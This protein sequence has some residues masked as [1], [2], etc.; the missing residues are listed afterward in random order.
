MDISAQELISRY[1]AQYA[2]ELPKESRD[3]ERRELE[4]NIE[5]MVQTRIE[6]GMNERHAVED[7]L[8][9]LGDPKDLAAETAGKTGGF[10]SLSG[11]YYKSFITTLP[12]VI[13]WTFVIYLM[14]SLLFFTLSIISGMEKLVFFN[15]YSLVEAV[16]YAGFITFIIY[17]VLEKAKIPLRGKAWS[18]ED[19]KKDQLAAN[20]I[21]RRCTTLLLLFA[22]AMQVLL[23]FLPDLLLRFTTGSNQEFIRESL[24]RGEVNWPSLLPYLTVF[25]G[26]IIIEQVYRLIHP[27][28]D[29]ST[30]IV[31][32]VINIA[33]VAALILFSLRVIEMEVIKTYVDSYSRSTS[34]TSVILLLVL[35]FALDSWSVFRKVR[36]AE[37]ARVEI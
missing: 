6:Q 14:L 16:I 23:I 10:L 31:N 26:I 25:F 8:S 11:Q 15:D 5:D 22:V 18:V 30:L 12:L 17:L 36:A 32:I 19:L 21:S 35:I 9:E 28:W 24:L 33:S 34:L 29:K 13:F 3:D 2:Q 20:Y 37:V 7:V 27:K 4:S 1:L